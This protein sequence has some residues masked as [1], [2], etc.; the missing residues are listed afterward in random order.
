MDPFLARTMVESLSKGVDPLT[1]RVLPESDSCYG[2][3]V[4]DALLEVLAHCTIE[5]NEQ[6]LIRIKEEKALKRKEMRKKYTKRYPR[7]GDAWT[8]AEERRLSELHRNGCS[9]YRIANI[10]QRTPGAIETRLKK[11]QMAPV[12]RNKISKDWSANR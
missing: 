4:Q 8:S 9:I 7:G 12:Y 5:S 6:Y 2:E 1:G 3:A 10:L 11:L